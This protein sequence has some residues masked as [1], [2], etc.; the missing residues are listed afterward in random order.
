MM[1]I[2]VDYSEDAH[3]DQLV[4]NSHLQLCL[5]ILNHL[6]FRGE[7]R[8]RDFCSKFALLALNVRNIVIL[9]TIASNSPINLKEKLSPLDEP[10]TC[11]TSFHASDLTDPLPQ[12]S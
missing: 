4:R 1:K 7:F 8:P 3:H 9:I 11:P 10:G 6:G 5:S 12:R 2:A